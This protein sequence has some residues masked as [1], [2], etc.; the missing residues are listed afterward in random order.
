VLLAQGK[1]HDALDAYQFSYQF[2]Q[3]VNNKGWMLTALTG[4]SRAEFALGDRSGAWSHARQALHLYLEAQKLYTFFVYLTV[5]EIALLLAD[6]GEIVQSLE[7]FGL[8]TRQGYLAGS[9]WFAELFGR[10]ID[11]AA[12]LLPLEEQTAAKER[13]QALDFAETIDKLLSSIR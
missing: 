4:L 2:F 13:G 9:H 11:E 5:A 12:A 8:V 3:S 10:F 6:R 7:L 1:Y